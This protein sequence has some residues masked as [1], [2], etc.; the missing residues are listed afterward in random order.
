MDA[1]DMV[2]NCFLVIGNKLVEVVPP[3]VSRS[4]VAVTAAAAA[5]LI[6]VLLVWISSSSEDWIE[7]R[8]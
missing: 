5:A 1:A 2:V 6:V 7:R 3:F 8:R 4:C